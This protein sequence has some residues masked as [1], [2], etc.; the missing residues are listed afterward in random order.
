VIILILF[1]LNNTTQLKMI[2]WIYFH[3][4]RKDGS[5]PLYMAKDVSTV[6]RQKSQIVGVKG[7]KQLL[8][9]CFL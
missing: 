4:S 1:Y 8:K 6:K 9:S 3:V 2:E 7:L 5:L